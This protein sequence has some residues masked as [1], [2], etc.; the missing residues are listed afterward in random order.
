[1]SLIKTAGEIERIRSAGRILSEVRTILLKLVKIGV[2]LSE[3]DGV[4][5]DEI[6]SRG[7]RPAFLGYRA[8]K[9]DK[10][11][12]NS[13]CAS[14]N[15]TIVHGLPNNYRLKS[16]DVLKLDLGV[17]YKGF[18]AD[19]AVTVGI[20]GISKEAHRLILGTEKALEEAIKEARAGKH[21]GDIGFAISRRAKLGKYCVV[22]GLTGHGIGKDL[23]EPPSVLN[24]GKKGQGM[25]LRS[26]MALAIEPMLAIGTSNIVLRRDGSY[27][28]E[29]GG[30]SAHFE[31]TVIITDGEAEIV[32][33]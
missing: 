30:L 24:E 21:L 13:I 15:D 25:A 8:S 20:G 18:N 5:K 10:P 14:I 16:G 26:G 29:N 31:H 11:Y 3:L 28:T 27:A 19:S 4:A 6:E 32:T 7:G 2:S 17:T 22:K 12:P 23:H 33:K 1:M 9:N